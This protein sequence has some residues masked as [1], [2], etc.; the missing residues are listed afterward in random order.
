MNASSFGLQPAYFF[1]DFDRT[2]EE[3]PVCLDCEYYGEPGYTNKVHS[4]RVKA[5]AKA[6]IFFDVC[7][8]L[9]DL[10]R[11]RIHFRLMCICF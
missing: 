11:F 3:N 6:K 4:H 8:F 1:P 2:W 9:F 7:R 10:F 5:K